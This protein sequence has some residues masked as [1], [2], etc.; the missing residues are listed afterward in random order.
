MFKTPFDL[1]YERVGATIYWRESE[2]KKEVVI[3]SKKG[4]IKYLLVDSKSGPTAL[5]QEMTEEE[6]KIEWYD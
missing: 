3:A 4:L 1:G 6:N 5:P 2:D